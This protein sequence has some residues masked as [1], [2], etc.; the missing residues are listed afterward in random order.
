MRRVSF[1]NIPF[2]AECPVCD[3]RGWHGMINA[4]NANCYECTGTGREP[5]PFAEIF[6]NYAADVAKEEEEFWD[7][8]KE[9]MYHYGLAVKAKREKK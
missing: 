8:I 4:K 2:D 7:Q 5:I 3:G 6:P 1:T 9:E